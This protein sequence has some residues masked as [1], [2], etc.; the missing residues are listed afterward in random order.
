MRAM[1]RESYATAHGRR[2]DAII[3]RRDIEGQ[4][5]DGKHIIIFE[6][7]VLKV[8]A[9]LKFHPGG[10]KAIK[11]MVGRDATDEINAYDIQLWHAAQ[12][13]RLPN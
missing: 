5:A 6:G 2:K 7:R 12:V 3:S 8:D 1:G 10:D 4:I 13:S 11:H 9:W